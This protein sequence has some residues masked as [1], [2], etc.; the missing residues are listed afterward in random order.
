MKTALLVD[1][2]DNKEVYT[3][4]KMILTT[5]TC[6]VSISWVKMVDSVTV[7]NTSFFFS[8]FNMSEN[9]LNELRTETDMRNRG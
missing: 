5:F 7:E 3:F 8:D 9:Q 2:Y 1:D 4:H 6:K